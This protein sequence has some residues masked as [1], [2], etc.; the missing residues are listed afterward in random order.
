MSAKIL[1]TLS[2]SMLLAAVAPPSA[3]FAQFLPPPPVAGPPPFLAGPLPGL[4]AGGPPPGLGAGDPPPRPWRRR[5]ATGWWSPGRTCCRSSSSWPR[6]RAFKRSRWG[7]RIA[8]F[9]PRRS[10]RYSRCRR[11][12]RGLQGQQCRRSLQPWL[13]GVGSCG[14]GW[15]YAYST[16]A[17]DHRTSYASSSDC[18]YGYSYRRYDKGR[19]LVCDG[20]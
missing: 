5:S 13:S 16:A 20:D 14:G 17:Y 6:G 19:V 15:A 10:G 11:S 8:W 7:W 12:R 3:A 2:T 1:L 9:R 4:G 18:Y